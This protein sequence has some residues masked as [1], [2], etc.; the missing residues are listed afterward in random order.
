MMGE[1]WKFQKGGLTRYVIRAPYI[2]RYLLT[3]R[4]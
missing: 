3:Y 2:Y 4:I 1:G